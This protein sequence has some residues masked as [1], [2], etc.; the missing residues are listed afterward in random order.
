M[1]R[2]I[3]SGSLSIDDEQG[4][5]KKLFSLTNS[6]I[7]LQNILVSIDVAYKGL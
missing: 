7:I 6:V 5:E 1:W 3:L 4:T 2:E